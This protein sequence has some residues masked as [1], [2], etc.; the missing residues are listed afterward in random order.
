MCSA[1]HAPDPTLLSV[2]HGYPSELHL[3]SFSCALARF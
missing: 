1:Q 2:H 3:S